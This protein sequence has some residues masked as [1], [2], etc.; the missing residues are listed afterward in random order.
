MTLH[1]PGGEV[2][3]GRSTRL[4]SLSSSSSSLS[5]SKLS[6]STTLRLL[7]TGGEV[8]ALYKITVIVLF[9]VVVVVKVITTDHPSAVWD[10]VSCEGALQHYNHCPHHHRGY[11]SYLHQPPFGCCTRVVSCQGALQHYIHCPHHHRCRRQ[12]YHHRPPF[13][14]FTRTHLHSLIWSSRTMGSCKWTWRCGPATKRWCQ[15][16]RR[17]R[18]PSTSSTWSPVEN[19]TDTDA[20]ISRRPHRYCGPNLTTTQCLGTVVWPSYRVV[21]M[22]GCRFEPGFMWPLLPKLT[23]LATICRESTTDP[24]WLHECTASL[25]IQSLRPQLIFC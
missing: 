22:S 15:G 17:R 7:H 24:L 16:F 12:S 20:F 10:M 3:W 2:R 9:I 4:P 6:P 19:V 25:A 13:G 23:A 14:C 5:S 18:S 8:R 11:Q 1:T 21:D